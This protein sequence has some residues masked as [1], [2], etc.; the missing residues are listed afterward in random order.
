MKFP[1]I[2][3]I[4]IAVCTDFLEK[5]RANYPSGKLY[6]VLD[7][8]GYFTS[9]IFKEYAKSIKIYHRWNKRCYYIYKKPYDISSQSMQF[10]AILTIRI[11]LLMTGF[12]YKIVQQLAHCYDIHAEKFSSTRKKNRPELDYIAQKISIQA[13][14]TQ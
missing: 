1:T 2:L 14:E 7:N 5:I 9:N 12:Y 13:H 3:Y 10:Y 6:L 11:I 8:A 4:Y